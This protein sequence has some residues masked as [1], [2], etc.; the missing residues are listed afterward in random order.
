M[1]LFESRQSSFERLVRAYSTE[2]YRYAYWLCRDRFTAEDL[3]QEA[4]ARAWRGWQNLRDGA[5]TK[6][7][8]YTILRNEHARLYER[9]RPEIDDSQELD[10][11]VDTGSGSVFDQFEMR[12]ALE[13]LPP[14]YREPLLLQVL[15]GFSSAEIGDMLKISEGVVMMRLTRARFALRK[16]VGNDVRCKVTERWIA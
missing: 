15:G 14:T 11:I 3:V 6:S 2:L 13:A 1:A 8:L 4:F 12:Q 10:E 16:I 7:W 5:A 9:K